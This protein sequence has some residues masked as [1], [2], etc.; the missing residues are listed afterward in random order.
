MK[1]LFYRTLF[2]ILIS[3]FLFIS[4]FSFIGFETSKFNAQINNKFKEFHKEL[5][6]ELNDV[7][8]ILNPF[9]LSVSAKTLGAKLKHNNKIID[10]EYI[11][12]KISL[13]S[14][15]KN[16]F[17]L[18]NLEASTTSQELKKLTSFA[19]SLSRNTE[20]FILEK[21]INKGYLIA[22]IKLNFDN[23]GNV[24]DDFEITGFVNDTKIIFS[25]SAR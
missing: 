17:S 15:M 16:D 4:Y 21:F 1:K 9:K 6:I 22:D 5:E 13:K 23:E 25:I 8:L 10:F 20:L 18:T 2:L 12:S 14:L 24:K 11:K 3:S 7:K 19:Q